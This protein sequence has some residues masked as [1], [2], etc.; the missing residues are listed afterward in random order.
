MPFHEEEEQ[1]RD[2][3]ST[4]QDEPEGN[5][6]RQ[7]MHGRIDALPTI[8]HEEDGER[9][10]L[11]REDYEVST[12]HTG[13]DESFDRE[14]LISRERVLTPELPMQRR[15]SLDWHRPPTPEMT[16]HQ[17]RTMSWER[18]KTP[19][20]PMGEGFYPVDTTYHGSCHPPYSPPQKHRSSDSYD[21]NLPPT[22]RIPVPTQTSNFPRDSEPSI[23]DPPQSSG[24]SS[25]SPLRIP[26]F[27]K[28]ARPQF[29]GVSGASRPP[30]NA[31]ATGE[32][33]YLM[34]RKPLPQLPPEAQALG[35]EVSAQCDWAYE[36]EDVESRRP[37]TRR[38]RIDSFKDDNKFEWERSSF[39]S[40]DRMLFPEGDYG[41]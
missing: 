17:E 6:E 2:F 21:P 38:R 18:P 22:L 24:T 3:S 14:S 26:S 30:L 40:E 35:N 19:D 10:S 27:A 36:D 37:S 39:G 7:P 20:L 25:L 33:I 4:I 16:L 9:Q 15:R 13:L 29:P 23:Y 34:G 5:E 1:A 32:S 8:I 11:R 28:R 12:L 31:V 41:K